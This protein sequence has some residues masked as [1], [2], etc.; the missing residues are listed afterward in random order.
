MLGSRRTAYRALVPLALALLLTAGAAS[1][2]EPAGPRLAVIKETRQP[3]RVTLLTVDPHGRAPMRIAGG[4]EWEGPVEARGQLSWRPDGSEI[5][6]PGI[7][8]IFVAAVDGS[9]AHELNISG[10]DRPV[11]APDGNTLAF[12]RYQEGGATTWTIDLATGTQRQL[13]PSRRGLEYVGS[14]FTPDGTTLLATRSDRK[15]KGRRELV[16]L[17]LDTGG[18]TRLIGNGFAPVYSPDAS[19]VAFLREVGKKQVVREEGLSWRAADLFVLDLASRSLRRLT[20]TP[21]RE[22]AFASWDPSGER[23]A[24]DRFRAGHFEWANSVVQIN[25]DGSCEDEVLARRRTVFVGTGWQPGPGRGA[26]RIRC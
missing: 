16:A 18:V 10:A 25:A 1:A 14:S 7:S 23:I 24:F 8:S 17:H 20:N 3:R 19:R 6:Y 22:E 13:T 15:R 26:G 5:A 11:F 4:Q 9:G 12:T 21:H 2:A